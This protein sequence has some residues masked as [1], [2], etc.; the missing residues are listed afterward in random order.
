M[1]LSQTFAAGLLLV[2]A[3]ALVGCSSPTEDHRTPP[4]SSH[5]ASAPSPEQSG[6]PTLTQTGPLIEPYSAL[7]GSTVRL[8]VGDALA[9][10]TEEI[11][12]DAVT[13]DVHNPA[14]VEFTPGRSDDNVSL[15]PGLTAMNEGTTSVRLAAGDRVVTFAIEVTA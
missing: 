11:P 15:R 5:S 13:A 9:I 1:K 2:A 8:S 4:E 10:D 12:V 3:V 7:D 14:V 6:Q